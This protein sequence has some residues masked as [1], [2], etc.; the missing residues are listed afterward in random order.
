M[1]KRFLILSLALMMALSGLAL[2]E[3]ADAAASNGVVILYTNDVHCAIDANIGYAGVAAYEKAYEDA[4]YDVL[5]VDC[6][7]AVQGAALAFQA[8]TIN[9][10]YVFQFYQHITP[11]S[12]P[13]APA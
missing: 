10:I 2:A 1:L 3:E 7:D 8:L 12:F 5:L 13:S 4:G 6:G 9:F 11:R